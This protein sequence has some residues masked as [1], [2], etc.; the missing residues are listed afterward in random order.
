MTVIWVYLAGWIVFTIM[1]FWCCKHEFGKMFK[2]WEYLFMST[3]LGFMSW[4]GILIVVLYILF[5]KY[6][7]NRKFY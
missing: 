5:N 7:E 3:I 4:F 1:I 6:F 2:I